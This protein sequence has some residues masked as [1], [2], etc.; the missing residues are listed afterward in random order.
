[1]DSRSELLPVGN[2]SKPVLFDALN[3]T[4]HRYEL[5]AATVIDE[6]RRLHKL[7]PSV[8]P[9]LGIL[10]AMAIYRQLASAAK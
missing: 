4:E 3:E 9:G 7:A 10:S 2:D 1:M 8:R 5:I 6:N